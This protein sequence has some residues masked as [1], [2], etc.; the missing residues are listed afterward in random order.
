MVH[1]QVQSARVSFRLWQLLLLLLDC[2]DWRR[3]TAVC[4]AQAVVCM[5]TRGKRIRVYAAPAAR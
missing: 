4:L 3:E 1:A 2:C 5:G